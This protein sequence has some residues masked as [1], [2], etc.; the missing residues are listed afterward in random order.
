MPNA[1]ASLSGSRDVVVAVVPRGT[2][3]PSMLQALALPPPVLRGSQAAPGTGPATELCMVSAPAPA[4]RAASGL[5]ARLLWPGGR[6]AP[7]VPAVG[8][9][10]CLNNPGIL[11]WVDTMCGSQS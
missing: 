3:D 4:V 1:S 9:G 7:Q 6:L 5:D 2:G 8:S 11:V 10:R